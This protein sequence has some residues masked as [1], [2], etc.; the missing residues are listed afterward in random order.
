VG[1]IRV[2]ASL[3]GV[4]GFR[5]TTGRWPRTGIAPISYTLDTPGPMARSVADCALLDSV[6]TGGAPPG[7]SEPIVSLRGVRFGVARRQFLEVVDPDVEQ[8]FDEA[9]AKLKA[10]GVGVEV[11]ELD[12]GEDFVQLAERANWPVFFHDTMPHVTEYLKEIG[13]PVTFTDIFEGLGSN[14]KNLWRDGVISGSFDSVS[15]AE[16]RASMEVDRPALRKRYA[17]AFRANGI[18]ALLFP[19]TPVAAPPLNTGEEVTIAGRIV[20]SVKLAKNAFPSSCAALPGITMPMG[21]S[22][23]GLPMGL[24]M[25]GRPGEDVKLLTLAAQVSAVLG[26]I[27]PPS[28]M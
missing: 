11:V 21:L 7:E 20:S 4:V 2:P 16:F 10:V 13:A 5:P 19:T 18:E 3:C 24:E 1:S 25:D 28:G 8:A 23:D 14:L 6:M 26:S 12:L 17:D 9:I 15:E 27:P 22:P